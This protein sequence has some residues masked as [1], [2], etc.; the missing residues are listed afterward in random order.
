MSSPM[1]TRSLA[2]HPPGTTVVGYPL[3]SGCACGSSVGYINPL[4]NQLRVFCEDCNTWLYHAPRVEFDA[5]E[6]RQ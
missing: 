1:F 5:W 2:D 4:S 6:A 3:R